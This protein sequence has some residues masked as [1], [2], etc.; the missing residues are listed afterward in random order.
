MLFSIDRGGGVVLVQL[1]LSSEFDNIDD[2]VL[3][4]LW[5]KHL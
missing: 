1:D 4:D 3:F 2:A 5:R